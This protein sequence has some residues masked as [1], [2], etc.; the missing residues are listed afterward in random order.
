[1][2][3]YQNPHLLST[4]INAFDALLVL[5]DF[6]PSGDVGP[7]ASYSFSRGFPETETQIWLLKEWLNCS[8]VLQSGFS[9]FIFLLS[10][11]K[12]F[13]PS[14]D[15]SMKIGIVGF[16]KPTA[17]RIRHCQCRQTF[18]RSG[19]HGTLSPMICWAL[20]AE[21]GTFAMPVALHIRFLVVQKFA[22]DLGDG[23]ILMGL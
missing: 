1:M 3:I 13:L 20:A 15:T 12:F 22:T 5:N 11:F 6:F 16:W 23:V 9:F 18:H 21:S 2:H 7:E 14:T 8:C 4:L 17:L 19:C 10:I